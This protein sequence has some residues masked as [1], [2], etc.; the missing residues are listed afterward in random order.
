MNL[1]CSSG[2]VAEWTRRQRPNRNIAPRAL[3]L[4]LSLGIWTASAPVFAE[5]DTDAAMEACLAEGK[6]L[7]GGEELIGLTK[8]LK[9][10]VEC[11]ENIQLAVF[12]SLDVHKQ[13]LYTLANGKQVFNFSDC[14]EYE[15]AAYLLDRE[16][17]LGMVPVSVLRKY[18]GTDGVLVAWIPDAVHEDRV[19]R[20]FSG[21]EMA[22]MTR[23]LSIVR[24]FD[25]LIYN[26]DRRPPN[27]LVNESIPKVFMIDHTQAFREKKELQKAFVE[28]RTWLPEESYSRLK[29]LDIDQLNE[30]LG[31]LTTRGQRKAL[32]ARRDLIIAKIDGEREDYGDEAVF[33]S[34][35]R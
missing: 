20:D 11:G 6:I 12:K 33:L 30:L 16:L 4:L 24:L 26:T 7:K 27:T 31:G 23:Q 35:A 17:G 18:R 34:P 28:G 13:G 10:E 32:L 19:K 22:S 29:A 1:V 3:C 25:S 9:V 8:P 21:P 2:F 14:F 5:L 15:R